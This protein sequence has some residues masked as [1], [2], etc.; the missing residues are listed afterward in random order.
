MPELRFSDEDIEQIEG[1]GMTPAKVIS[2]IKMFKKGLS[3]ARLRRPCTVG[4][5]I[6]VLHKEDVDR[7][8]RLFLRLL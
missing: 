2:Q 5:G 7:L 1:R 8:G 6:T 3:Y 4:D